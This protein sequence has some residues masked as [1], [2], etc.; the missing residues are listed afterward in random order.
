MGG[1]RSL[2]GRVGRC[3]TLDERD[4][5]DERDEKP[6]EHTKLSTVVDVV[7]YPPAG[8]RFQKT[9]STTNDN[10]SRCRHFVKTPLVHLRFVNTRGVA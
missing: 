9:T 3:L 4:K 5:K 7:S 8:T 10:L 1:L 6:A 2:R